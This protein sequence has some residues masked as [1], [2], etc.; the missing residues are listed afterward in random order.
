MSVDNTP[1]QPSLFG[2][3]LDTKFGSEKIEINSK[4]FV[5]NFLADEVIIRSLIYSLRFM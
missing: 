1:K 3:F 4:Q 5:E 2:K